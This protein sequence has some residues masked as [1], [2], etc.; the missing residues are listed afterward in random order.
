[1]TCS[2][3]PLQSAG[4]GPGPA[5]GWER[6]RGRVRG[7]R[8]SKVCFSDKRCDLLSLGPPKRA[9][10]IILRAHSRIVF[11][12]HYKTRVLPGPNLYSSILRYDLKMINDN[13]QIIGPVAL[14]DPILIHPFSFVF[15]KTKEINCI[16]PKSLRWPPLWEAVGH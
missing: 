12:V 8:V 7:R 15:I 4:P 1:M 11:T 9:S 16:V 10:F 3:L 14:L 13:E 5:S 2:L 6:A